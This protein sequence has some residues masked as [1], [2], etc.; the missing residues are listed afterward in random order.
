[1]QQQVRLPTGYHIDWAGEYENQKRSQRRLLIVLPITILIIY[2]ILFTMFKSAKWAAL[3]LANVSM[4]PIGGILALLLTGTHFS[5]SSGVGFLALFGVS[6]QVGVIMI[7][8]INHLR[9]R[10]YSIEDA[11]VEGAI[12]RLR[13]IMM[14]MLIATLGLL[15]A[16]LSRHRLRF[17]TAIRHRDCRR[18]A[19]GPVHE[20]LSATDDVRLGG[21]GHGST[22]PGGCR[23]R[24][25]H[26]RK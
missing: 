23:N 2:I 18:A 10:G 3:T 24:R 11:A 16:A 15:P 6:V 13:P 14:T 19:G 9:A 8:Y 12:L 17:A 21:P 25:S 26:L 22:A 5:V 4:A 20:H 1:M 7:E